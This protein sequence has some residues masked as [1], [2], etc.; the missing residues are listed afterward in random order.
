MV[1]T[2]LT[3][4]FDIVICFKV[5]L[6]SYYSWSLLKLEPDLAKEKRNRFQTEEI[7]H[8]KPYIGWGLNK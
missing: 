7:D 4:T 2:G 5:T 3:F 6:H 8:Y 1:F